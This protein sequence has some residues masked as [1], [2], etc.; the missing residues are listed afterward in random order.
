MKVAFQGE[1]G[2]YSELAAREYYGQDIAVV[3][4][5]TFTDVFDRVATGQVDAGIIP[6]ENSL[7]GSVHENYDLLI[8]HA[9]SI[10]GE[11]KPSGSCTIS[12]RT[13]A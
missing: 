13:R 9:L 1:L 7:A 4:S 6:I 11:I 3:P 8:E 2:A 5:P 10:V 12:S